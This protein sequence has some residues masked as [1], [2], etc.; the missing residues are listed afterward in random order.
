M[1][2]FNKKELEF[3]K[4]HIALDRILTRQRARIQRERT[5]RQLTKRNKAN[6]SNAL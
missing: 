5:E 6:Q 2:E 1:R 4:R 3:V